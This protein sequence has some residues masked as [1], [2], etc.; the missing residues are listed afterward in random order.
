ME[1]V[2]SHQFHKNPYISNLT[3]IRPM[4]AELFHVGGQAEGHDKV[5]SLFANFANVP[6]KR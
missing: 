6:E 5:K 1:F 2:L 3:K 4:G